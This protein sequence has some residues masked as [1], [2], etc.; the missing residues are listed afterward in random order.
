MVRVGTV[1]R[2]IYSNKYESMFT[3]ELITYKLWR[4]NGQFQSRGCQSKRNMYP[5]AQLTG[6]HGIVPNKEIL[7]LF[8]PNLSFNCLP[9]K[10][11]DTDE[12]DTSYKWSQ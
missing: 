11:G 5:V 1:F 2:M 6:N 8:L 7:Y 4:P 12:S 3:L 9:I 10:R